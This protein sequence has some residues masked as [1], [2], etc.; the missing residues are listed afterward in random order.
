VHAEAVLAAGYED[1]V[2]T[3]AFCADTFHAHQRVLRSA[4]EAAR[5][6]DGDHVA[7]MNLFGERV[8]VPRFSPHN[9]SDEA[10]GLVEAMALYCGQGAGAVTRR[11]PAAAIV[12]DLAARL[13]LFAN[14]D[15][16][17]VGTAR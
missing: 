16:R 14:E 4:L 10:T 15:A 1:T 3:D 8:I 2:L 17:A 7:E 6:F 5:A 11:E 9:P 13:P 12:A